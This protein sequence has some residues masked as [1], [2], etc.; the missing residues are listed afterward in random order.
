MN[1]GELT[2]IE[3]FRQRFGSHPRVPVGIGDDAAVVTA[4][5]G[6]Q[7]LVAADMLL[8]GVHFDLQ[9]HD[10]ADAG[11]KALAVNVSDI[12]AMGGV[13]TA[14][15]VTLAIPRNPHSTQLIQRVY[16]G[17]ERCARAYG[18]AIAGGDTNA[19]SDPFAISVTLMGD[20]H[21]RGP[22]LRS[23]ARTGD[24]ILV[25]GELG[26]SFATHHHLTFQPRVKEARAWLDRHEIHAMIDL[27]D[28]LATD[29][30]H[31]LVAS[32][33]KGARLT[34]Q[35]IPV[36]ASLR[37][38]PFDDALR[39]ALTDGE[40]FE[41]CLTVSPSVAAALQTENPLGLKLTDVGAVTDDPLDL[42]WETGDN[43][44]ERI[45]LQGYEHTLSR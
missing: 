5:N 43:C 45:S 30:R 17:L 40:D 33:G 11:W 18:I 13:P 9:K 25:S 23:G 32:G 27:S 3:S 39:R 31:V 36:R 20:P 22:V 10:P 35:A 38:L 4:S 24:R 8:D 44:L 28:G 6:A 12:A 15:F 1:G 37:S 16:E 34:R 21:A 42:Y 26:D 7:Q 41:L 29:L 19:W 2:L 14:A